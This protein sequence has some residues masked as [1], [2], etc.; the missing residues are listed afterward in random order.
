MELARAAL[1][2][3]ERMY[4]PGYAYLKAGVI[5]GDFVSDEYQQAQLFDAPPDPS[6]AELMQ[7]IDEINARF[8]RETIRLLATGT[9]RV[10][11]MK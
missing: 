1:A 5:L 2:G 11:R 8:G 4:K 3:L 7:T 6:R 9:D 10:W